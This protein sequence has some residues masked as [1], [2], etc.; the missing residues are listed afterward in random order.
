MPRIEGPYPCIRSN[1]AD[2][3]GGNQGWFADDANF[4]A[5]GCGVIAGADVLLYLSGRRELTREEYFRFVGSLRRYFPLIPR[6]GIDGLRLAL[7]LNG[8]FR[9]RRLPY[10]C[11]WSVSGAR[12]WERLE[13]MLADDLPA[14]TAIGPNFPRVWG[15]EELTLYRRNGAGGYAVSE[16]TRGHFLTVTGLD[17][18]WM[19]VSSWGR[20][21]FLRRSDYAA[22]M[23]RNGP[24][25]TNLLFMERLR[26]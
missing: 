23:R 18:E 15:R 10:R 12:F 25:F 5:C 2:S 13:G 20:R 4:R 14:I 6:R 16:Q 17:E 8:C 7:G 11:G 3:Y 1:G 9:R 26:P 19:E 22:Y 21:L 24:M